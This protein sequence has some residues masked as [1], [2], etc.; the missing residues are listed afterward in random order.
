MNG[1]GFVFVLAPCFQCKATFSFNPHKVP[2]IPVHGT[3]QPFCR[4]C[5]ERMAEMMNLK[6][7]G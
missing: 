4:A 3:R 7:N 6:E 5:V 1:G 2:S